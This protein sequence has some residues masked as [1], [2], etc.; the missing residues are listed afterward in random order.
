MANSQAFFY[1]GTNL[2]KRKVGTAVPAV[3]KNN[4]AGKLSAEDL[5]DH[6][7]SPL[8]QALDLLDDYGGAV[9]HHLGSATHDD[10]S[11]E[12]QADD[13]VGIK[14]LRLFHHA[15]ER[16]LSTLC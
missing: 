15:V 12:L 2:A 5:V 16:L 14:H 7:I 10:R 13:C 8:G 3:L 4:S 1:E 11:L 6:S 9:G